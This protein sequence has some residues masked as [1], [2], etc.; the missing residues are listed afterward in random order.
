MQMGFDARAVASRLM[1]LSL[2]AA[3]GCSDKDV[4]PAPDA[5][6]GTGGNASGAGSTGTGAGGST[7]TGAGGTGSGGSAGSGGAGGTGTAGDAATGACTNGAD[8]AVIGNAAKFEQ[9]I[10]DCGTTCFFSPGDKAVCA[11]DCMRGKGL[12]SGCA[13]CYG[14]QIACGT[15][16]CSVPCLANSSSPECRAC[17][18][19]N[20]EPPFRA[21]A[22]DP[23]P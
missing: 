12:S 1:V 21:C 7:G 8:Q 4:S 23:P 20:C 9:D 13:A 15:V 19:Q 3:G 10:T 2:C 16:T 22:G 11:S 14:G 5:T 17:V 18:M 6:A